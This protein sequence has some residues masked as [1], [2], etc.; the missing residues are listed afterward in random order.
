MRISLP[1]KHLHDPL[2]DGSPGDQ[3]MNDDRLSLSAPVQSRTGL[4]VFLKA[5]RQAVPD[6]YMPACLKVQAVSC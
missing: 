2:I 1:G 6:D 3:M 5:P 4:L